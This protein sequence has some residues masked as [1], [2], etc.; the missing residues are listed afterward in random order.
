MLG[1]EGVLSD[2]R[3]LDLT[4]YVAGPYCTKLLADYGAEVIKV[5]KPGEGDGARNIGPFPGDELHPEKSG[6]FLYLNTNKKGVT[7]NLRSDK[8]QYIL[9]EMVR[10]ADILVENFEPAVMPSWGLSYETLK[11][12]NPRLIMLSISNFGQDGPYAGYKAYS[13]VASAIGGATYI[14]GVKDQPLRLPGNIPQYMAG[15]QGFSSC[16]LALYGSGN[17]GE[18]QH[19]DLSIAE[20]VACNLEAATVLYC[21][22]G[23]LRRRT[24]TRFMV[25]HPVGIYPCR[26]GHVVI[27]PGLGN[28]PL[29]AILVENPELADHP[30]FQNPYARQEQPEEFDAL[31]LPWL[32][33]H[34]RKDILADAQRLGMPFG[35]VCTPDE[36][37]EDLHLAERGYFTYIDHPCA[38]QLK[39]PGLPFDLGS[40]QAEMKPAPLLGEHNTEVFGR[41]GYT[42]EQLVTLR[43]T[44]VI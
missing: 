29:L 28:M 16:L 11:E 20:S 43:E 23:V 13:A 26:D 8:G 32:M 5:E 36:V 12:V 4:Q 41:L 10:E 34:D 38:G 2:V 30:L 22:T 14:S 18:G 35:L 42:D 7:L 39:M 9:R 3:V 15:T 19:I 27:I 44:G 33:E 25:G 21:Y 31:I 37:L 1:Q 40:S 17:S 6:L 24:F